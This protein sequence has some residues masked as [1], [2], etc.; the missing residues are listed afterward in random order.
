MFTELNKTKLL[1][2]ILVVL[3]I[4]LLQY[5]ISDILE[6][7]SIPLISFLQKDKYLVR[8]MEIVSFLGSKPVKFVIMIVLYCF[9][10]IYHCFIYTFGSYFSMF[11][12]AWMKILFQEN[13]PYWMSDTVRPIECEPGFGYPSNHVLTTVVCFFTLFDILYKHYEIEKSVNAKIFYYVG[14][15]ITF[16]LCLSIGFARMVLGVHSID[17]ILFGLLMG[18]MCYYFFIHLLNIDIGNYEGFIKI[19]MSKYQLA[20][21]FIAYN[22]VYIVF[23]FSVYFSSTNY[24]TEFVGRVL[25]QCPGSTPFAK[26]VLASGQYFMIAGMMLGIIIDTKL[27][28]TDKCEEKMVAVEYYQENFADSKEETST[29]PYLIFITKILI[30][31][32]SASLIRIVTSLGP[33]FIGVNLPSKFIFQNFIY[34]ILFGIYLFGYGRKIINYIKSKES[35]D[36]SK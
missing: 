9:C 35:V 33:Y 3:F 18:F 4:T 24:N 29:H 2:F 17:Q 7:L 14:F 12:C 34:L 32:F 21:F 5:F 25:S 10:N 13:R 16:L 1:I 36:K 8:S 15:S 23:L 26:C 22:T 11:L 31:M 20:K 6:E 27:N 30:F 19:I 28:Y